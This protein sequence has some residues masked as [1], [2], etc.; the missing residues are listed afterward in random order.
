MPYKSEAQR[1]LMHHLVAQGKLSPSVVK[2]YDRESK[3]KDLPEYVGKKAFGGRV[4]AKHGVRCPACDYP[5]DQSGLAL[6][7][8]E[9]CPRCGYGSAKDV[10][11][12]ARGGMHYGM[13]K[14][15]SGRGG[16]V[17]DTTAYRARGGVTQPHGG[18][19]GLE[20]ASMAVARGGEMK[21]SH[22][23]YAHGGTVKKCAR[24][25]YAMGGE[26][27]GPLHADLKEMYPTKPER[28]ADLDDGQIRNFGNLFAKAI[29]LR[30]R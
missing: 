14:S 16:E 7:A 29:K 30:R 6:D 22:C 9:A 13:P 26:V 23:G 10:P 18:G 21:C 19:G 15:S 24:C 25:G 8:G 2:E 3:G 28:G 27:G 4:A 12:R 11:H 17:M 20:T 1:K 5:I